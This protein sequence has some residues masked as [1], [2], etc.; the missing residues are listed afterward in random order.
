MSLWKTPLVFLWEKL[1]LFCH[2]DPH[3]LMPEN[4]E[5]PEVKEDPQNRT[6]SLLRCPGPLVHVSPWHMTMYVKPEVTDGSWCL[7]EHC[8]ALG[9]VEKMGL[10]KD[11][12]NVLILGYNC[13]CDCSVEHDIVLNRCGCIS[14]PKRLCGCK[15][16]VLSACHRCHITLGCSDVYC[17]YCADLEKVCPCEKPL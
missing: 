14:G 4:P 6:K 16:E 17:S 8:Y 12:L 3:S 1:N 10:K 9:C 5:V 11:T 7:C 13:S 15:Q 2:L